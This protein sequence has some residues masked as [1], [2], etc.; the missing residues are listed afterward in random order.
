M[1]I[2]GLIGK[3]LWVRMDFQSFS[4]VDSRGQLRQTSQPLKRSSDVEIMA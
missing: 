4:L 3:V 2:K 1:T